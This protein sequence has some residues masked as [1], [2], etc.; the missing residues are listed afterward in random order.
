MKALAFRIEDVVYKAPGPEPF[1]VTLNLLQTS[2]CIDPQRN[3]TT[4]PVSTFSVNARSS[5]G[6]ADENELGSREM[7][8]KNEYPSDQCM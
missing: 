4:A 2:I 6:N 5:G 7:T 3:W 8:D 1:K